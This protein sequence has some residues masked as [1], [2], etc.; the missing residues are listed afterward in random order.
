METDVTR[1]AYETKEPE[2]FQGANPEQQIHNNAHHHSKIWTHVLL[3]FFFYNS[4]YVHM[5]DIK[6]I[7]CPNF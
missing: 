6:F 5:L 2:L 4:M 7:R 3:H 1:E